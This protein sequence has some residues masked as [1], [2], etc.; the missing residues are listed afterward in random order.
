MK[1]KGILEI[2]LDTTKQGNYKI[3]SLKEDTLS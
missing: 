1:Q 3:L 2:K